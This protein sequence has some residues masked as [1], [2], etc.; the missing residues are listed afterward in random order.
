MH[1]RRVR[2]FL[3]EKVLAICR[4]LEEFHSNPSLMGRT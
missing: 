2:I 1:P 3:A 4:H